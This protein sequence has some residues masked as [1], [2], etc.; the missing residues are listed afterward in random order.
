M[1]EYDTERLSFLVI[2]GILMMRNRSTRH[3]ATLLMDTLRFDYGIP[4][5]VMTDTRC[6][7][8]RTQLDLLRGAPSKLPEVSYEE[9]VA[10]LPF[11]K[12]VAGSKRLDRRVLHAAR[13]FVEYR[14]ERWHLPADIG[15]DALR[16]FYERIAS[17]DAQE[18]YHKAKRFVA[19]CDK[20]L[21]GNRADFASSVHHTLDDSDPNVLLYKRRAHAYHLKIVLGHQYVEAL[22]SEPQLAA[23]KRHDTVEVRE[24]LC[25]QAY[26]DI[27]GGMSAE[28]ARKFDAL[29][30]IKHKTGLMV[31]KWILGG[32]FGVS[33]RRRD[34]KPGRTNFDL[35]QLRETCIQ[36]MAR[37]FGADIRRKPV[38][39]FRSAGPPRGN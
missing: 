32:A 31:A 17:S 27:V 23:L 16:Q 37:D 15:E 35:I 38:F 14:T 26:R 22:L 39:L 12:S 28:D 18:L 25:E 34:K 6:E 13:R 19:L 2:V 9:V 1:L 20:T 7:L 36:D 33:V 24:G 10:A 11:V 8:D 30:E 3:F 5:P 4:C 21:D 29:F